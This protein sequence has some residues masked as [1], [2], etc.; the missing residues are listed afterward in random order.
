MY[1]L[2]VDNW[3]IDQQ[4]YAIHKIKIYQ[5][6]P[7]TNKNHANSYYSCSKSTQGSERII[8]GNVYAI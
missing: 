5:R 8:Y 3:T 7:L 4:M 6:K 1:N 2:Y